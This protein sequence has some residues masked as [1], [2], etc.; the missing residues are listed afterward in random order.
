VRLAT[1]V[2]V[3][4]KS[5]SLSDLD[6]AIGQVRAATAA[7]GE[8]RDRILDFCRLHDDALHR[9]CLEGHLTGSALVVDP[10]TM[11]VLLLHHVKLDRWLQPGGHADG[12]GDL[13]R[14]ALREAE[15]ETGLTDLF[16]VTPAVD[17]DIHEIPA[18]AGEPAH[19]HL[20]VRFLVLAEGD[21][22]VTINHEAFDARWIDHRDPDRLIGSA[23]LRRLI[24]RGLAV[25]NSLPR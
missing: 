2:A 16:L 23:E 10:S 3:A 8:A 12:D 19:V 14:V 18:R 7:D 13:G 5:T 6:E 22:D 9:T 24:S 4:R 21:T 1:V 17:L 15:E 25:V 11:R 20:D